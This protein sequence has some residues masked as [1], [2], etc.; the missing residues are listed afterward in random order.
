MALKPDRNELDVDIAE[1]PD[2]LKL[3]EPLAGP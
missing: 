2:A 1:D 3:T